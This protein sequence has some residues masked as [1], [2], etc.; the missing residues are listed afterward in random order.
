[1]VHQSM[2]GWVSVVQEGWLICIG[3][4]QLSKCVRILGDTT[5]TFGKGNFKYRKEGNNKAEVLHW[6]WRSPHELTLFSVYVCVYA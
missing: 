2:W 6:D 4:H 5:L 1:M 3:V